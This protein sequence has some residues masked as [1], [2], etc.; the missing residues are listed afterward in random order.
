MASYSPDK[1]YTSGVEIENATVATTGEHLTAV[2]AEEKIHNADDALQ[3]VAEH[4]VQFTPEEER[5][6]RRKID[7][8]LVPIM[9]V[10]NGIQFVDKLTISYAAT[11]GLIKEAHLK[12]Q[13]F[14]TLITLF[15]VGYL[16]AQYPANYIMQRYPVGKVITIA[17]LLWGI[18]LATMGSAT[19][20]STLAAA[21]FFLGVFESCVNPGFILITSS[22]WKREEQMARIGFW[23]S[24]NGLFGLPA[25]MIF[26]G[27][28]HI[29]SSL[30]PYQWMFIIFGVLTIIIGISLWWTMPDSPTNARFLTERE[31]AIAVE[32]L[33][34]NK[35]GIKNAQHKP[36]QII[37]CLTDVK[38]WLLVFGIFWHNMTNS[39]QTN[40]LGLILKG[41]G[42][43]TYEAVLFNLPA[44]AVAAAAILLISL[45]N[46]SRHIEG[47]R[48]FL[49]MALYLPGIMACAILY[50]VPLKRSN[51]AIHLFAVWSVPAVAAAAGVQYSLLASNVA[52]YTKKTIAGAM[53]FAAYCVANIVT[54]QTFLA[55]QAPKYTTG[56]I[57]TLSAFCINIALFAILYVLYRAENAK[58]NRLDEG[59]VSLDQTVDL[60]DSF[61][62]LT[63][64][65]NKKMRYKL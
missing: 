10:V 21:R 38:V 53:F 33:S 5:S 49:I 22:W 60:I 48:I 65:Q 45:L 50:V 32:R 8:R 31:R 46:R 59:E 9:L 16:V 61:S 25:V 23:Y 43:S 17:F 57:V 37:E 11:Y 63:D 15:Y 6:V 62:D 30:Y 47:R 54:P 64:K 26:Y 55:S 18:T 29:K 7:W 24:A 51:R 40:F 58:R 20:F 52:G 41:Y 56:V 42:Y 13:Q 12:G 44:S 3:F 1:A 27:I 34:S 36:S 4:F 35:T 2:I 28:A 19:K 14:S 39:L